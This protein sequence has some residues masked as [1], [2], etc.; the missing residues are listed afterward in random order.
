MYDQSFLLP[1]TLQSNRLGV[2]ASHHVLCTWRN[3][4]HKPPSKS[5]YL[6]YLKF[7]Q[8]VSNLPQFKFVNQKIITLLALL[9]QQGHLPP[10]LY[11]TDLD[12]DNNLFPFPFFSK[13]S[14]EQRNLFAVL[15]YFYLFFPFQT[16]EA[17]NFISAINI[18]IDQ[19]DLPFY[20][21][22][23]L[24][25]DPTFMWKNDNLPSLALLPSPLKYMQD[26]ITSKISTYS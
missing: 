7:L 22:E 26:N 10:S 17:L 5:Y 25:L 18:I 2:E 8:N 9:L 15:Q 3:L 20:Q 19:L 13:K 16:Q 12:I 4:T 23:I 1:L 24:Y 14:I 11:D 6:D 21:K